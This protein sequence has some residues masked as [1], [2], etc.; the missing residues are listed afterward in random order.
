MIVGNYRLMIFAWNSRNRPLS[1]D[2][3]REMHK[4]G[5]EGI[6]D[7][8][9]IPGNFRKSDDVHVVNSDGEGEV[10]YIPPS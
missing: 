7:D 8:T 1:L 3:L 9:Y 5:V 6:D 10:V 2:L 4:V